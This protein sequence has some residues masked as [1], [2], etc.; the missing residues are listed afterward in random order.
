MFRY[1]ADCGMR[2]E[3][4]DDVEKLCKSGLQYE[5]SGAGSNSAGLSFGVV[6]WLTL[7][8]TVASLPRGVFA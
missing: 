5:W 1:G 3:A 8:A 7:L 4:G 6:F 2:V